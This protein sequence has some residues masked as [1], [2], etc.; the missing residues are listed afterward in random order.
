MATITIDTSELV[1]GQPNDVAD[2][3]AAFNAILAQCN[4]NLDSTN[5]NLAASFGPFS[6]AFTF[7]AA[8][9]KIKGAGAGVA[10]LQ[11]ANSGTNRTI[12][13]PDLGA[14]I[15]IASIQ[16]MPIGTVINGKLS[17]AAGLLKIVG[18]NG[19]DLSS[20][21]PMYIVAANSTGGKTVL[22]YTTSP[23][24]SDSTA[25]DSDFV[26][27]GTW[28]WGTTAAV[29]WANDMPI[30]LQAGTDG[31][32]PH[33]FMCRGPVLTTGAST[34]I[35]YQDNAAS[36]ASQNNVG[37][38]TATNVSSTHANQVLTPIGA[39]RA[40]KNSSD[41]W[42]FTALGNGD[43][44]N[45]FYNFGSR[46][47]DVPL[48]QN[49]ATSGKYGKNNG[50]TFPTF[51]AQNIFKYKLTL[52]GGLIFDQRLRNTSG[53]TLGAGAVD[54]IVCMPLIPQS[55]DSSRFNRGLALIQ[56]VG[57]SCFGEWEVV[58]N[59]SD[60]KYAY[61]STTPTATAQVQNTEMN[62][63]ARTL[64]CYGNYQVFA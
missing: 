62:Q 25:G 43:G 2:V 60:M 14:D 22:T 20:S 7:N 47:Y 38:M 37:A 58:N 53:G 59:S 44:L 64:E 6:N 61:T 27:T 51:T 46:E 1:N 32:T 33:V 63:A 52:A 31:T 5:L 16:N 41:N 35:G 23:S 39:F 50:G 17:L 42:T 3:I 55:A 26:G 9:A 30:L 48:G 15:I 57:V 54:T 40:Q 18:D 34:N 13:V 12:T 10:S 4:G 45:V 36:S 8:V 19:S 28:S 24:F 21:N 11:Y 29:A 49:G 56:G